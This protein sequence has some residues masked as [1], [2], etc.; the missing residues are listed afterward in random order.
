M[1]QIRNQALREPLVDSVGHT[2]IVSSLCPVADINLQTVQKADLEFTSTYKLHINRK[3][4]AH[5]LVGWFEVGFFHCHKPVI[6][7]T[8]PRHNKTH[9]KQVVFYLDNPVDVNAGDVM[10]GSFAL[11]KNPEQQREL[12]IKVSYNVGETHSVQFYRLR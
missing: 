5:A 7:S 11:R 1:G 3:D 4:T 8:S 9:W 2:P 12:D 10:E 6:L